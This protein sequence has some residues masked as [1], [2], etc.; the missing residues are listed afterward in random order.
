MLN[1]EEVEMLK[2]VKS[3]PKK[4]LEK[5]IFLNGWGVLI[6]TLIFFIVLPGVVFPKI[7]RLGGILDWAQGASIIFGF[8]YLLIIKLLNIICHLDGGVNEN[9]IRSQA[10]DESED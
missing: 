9:E 7:N 4:H 6:V 5:S 8:L 1:K 10:H 3:L 2:W